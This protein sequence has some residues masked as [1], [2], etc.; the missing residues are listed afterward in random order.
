MMSYLVISRYHVISRYVLKAVCG[1]NV[2]ECC[3]AASHVGCHLLM[4]SLLWAL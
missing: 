3:T 2:H 4:Q 1:M